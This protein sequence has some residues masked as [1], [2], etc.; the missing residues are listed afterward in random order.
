VV[1]GCSFWKG[2]VTLRGG[3][4]LWLRQLGGRISTGAKL[5]W[6]IDLGSPGA[7]A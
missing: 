2:C 7:A 3:I 1:R 4:F 6:F 5:S